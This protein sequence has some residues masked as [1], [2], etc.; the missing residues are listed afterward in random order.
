MALC[1]GT[2]DFETSHWD[3]ELTMYYFDFTISLS[4]KIVSQSLV[5]AAIL[6]RALDSITSYYF[7]KAFFFIEWVINPHTQ[8]LSNLLWYQNCELLLNFWFLW[9][10]KIFLYCNDC[11]VYLFCHYLNLKPLTF[12]LSWLL[13]LN[14]YFIITARSCWV[15]MSFFR[16]MYSSLIIA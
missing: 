8:F 9:L 11:I 13:I 6:R 7:R 4:V 5:T 2:C 12:L 10:R 3:V 1:W 14:S 16:R 15:N